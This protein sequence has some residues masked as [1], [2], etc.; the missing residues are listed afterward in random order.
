MAIIINNKNKYNNRK[1]IVDGIKFDSQKEAQRYVVLKDMEKCKEIFGLKLQPKFILQDKFR[2][3]DHTKKSGWRT[4]R[5]ITYK[6]D[7]QYTIK[8]VTQKTEVKKTA[9][10]VEDVKGI[11]TET[12]KIKRKLFLKKFP[13]YK[14]VEI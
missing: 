11:K 3:S 10:V 4:E 2:V 12:Y 14:F 5:A 1:T 9:L 8:L 7:F 6:A 13:E